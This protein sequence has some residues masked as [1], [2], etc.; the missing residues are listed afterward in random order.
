VRRSLAFLLA[1][2]GLL[3]VAVGVV[4]R[5][6]RPPWREYNDE[7]VEIYPAQ[8]G[9]VERCLT[10]HAGI[11]EISPSHSVEVFGCVSCHRGVGAALEQDLAHAGLVVNPGDLTA[12]AEAC[13][14]CHSD[15]VYRVERSIQATYAGAIALV[16][17]AFGAQ[18][19]EIARMGMLAVQAEIGGSGTLAALELLQF[20]PDDPPLLHQF[21][22]NCLNCHLQG[23]P[24]QQ[25]YFYRSTGCSACH[26]LY[27]NDGL[28][29]GSDPTIPPDE[30]G[31][32]SQHRMTT[33]IPY[34]Q[35]NH[36]HNRGNYEL[37]TMSFTQRSDLGSPGMDT[38]ERRLAEYYQPIG[39]FTLCEW[40]LD[41]IDC[42]TQQEAMGDGHLYSNQ[43][44][45]QYVTCAA[46]HGTLTQPPQT[47]VLTEDDDLALR[48]AALNPFLDTQ[49][50]QTVIATERGELFTHVVQQP[51]G[52][53]ELTGRANGIRYLTPLVMGSA[54]QQKPDQQESHYCHECHAYERE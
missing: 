54:C 30:P 16:R 52:T 7:V 32:A 22:Q 47:H 33:A 34:W 23:D 35:C 4:I 49:P 43:T 6:E 36:C 29:Q 38:R 53:F 3:L 24:I 8:T 50:G 46:C 21:G 40:E 48:L 25:A 41:C 17:R 28:Y 5:Q 14:G 19:D 31:H 39:Q 10:C 37:P 11:E 26:V 2:V 51:D 27:A 1:A 42:H 9:Q 18:P 44:E 13:G 15:Q 45:A 12:A 20:H